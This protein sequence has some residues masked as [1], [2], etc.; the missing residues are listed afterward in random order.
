MLELIFITIIVLIIVGILGGLLYLGYSPIK[1]R[2]LRSGKIFNKLDK[3]INISYLIFLCLLVIFLV[4]NRD[5]RTSSKNRLEVSSGIKLPTEFKV[6]KDEYQDMLQD[7]CINYDIKFDNDSTVQL[8][9]K[10][11]GS[12]F[13]KANVNPKSILSD[14]VFVH[15]DQT[16]AIWF[17]SD[18]GYRFNRQDARTDYSIDLDT[19]TNI[20]RYNECAD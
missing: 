8:I 17:K 13:Y 6:L 16:K 19:V 12:K 10:I 9:K 11:K 3:R 1:K 20:L 18:K 5:Y 14:S 15:I 2:L 4:Y 7:Y